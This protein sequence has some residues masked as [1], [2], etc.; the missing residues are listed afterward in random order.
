MKNRF[1]NLNFVILDRYNFCQAI[2]NYIL[3]LDRYIYRDIY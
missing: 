3:N 1:R 2:E